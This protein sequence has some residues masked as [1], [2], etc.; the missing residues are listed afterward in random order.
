MAEQMAGEVSVAKIK[1]RDASLEA[2]S[3][4]KSDCSQYLS[5]HFTINAD[6]CESVAES[7]SCAEPE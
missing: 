3:R 4:S 1:R 5:L 7:A 6:I 2:K